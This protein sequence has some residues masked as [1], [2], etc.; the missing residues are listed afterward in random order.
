MTKET[1]SKRLLRAA[2]P[3]RSVEWEQRHLSVPRAAAFFPI[4]A[5]DV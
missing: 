4:S 3:K 1:Y 5:S 2:R